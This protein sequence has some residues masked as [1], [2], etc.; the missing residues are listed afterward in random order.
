[1][2]SFA[3]KQQCYTTFTNAILYYIVFDL[4]RLKQED[5]MI[6]RTQGEHANKYTIVAVE[7][8]LKYMYMYDCTINIF[9]Y[10]L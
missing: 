4:T 2:C 10:Y 6:Y 1:M 3:E 7:N 5:P 9:V 8:V